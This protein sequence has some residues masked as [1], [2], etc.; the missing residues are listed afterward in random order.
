MD[1]QNFKTNLFNTPPP[2]GVI[3]EKDYKFIR[4]KY[5]NKD[6]VIFKFSDTN[7]TIMTSIYFDNEPL[8]LNTLD[9]CKIS[10]KLSGK[11]IPSIIDFIHEC[12][13]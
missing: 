4:I 3:V 1:F 9:K 7:I 8:V 5:R 11:T 2:L 10:S 6:S 12:I 13:L